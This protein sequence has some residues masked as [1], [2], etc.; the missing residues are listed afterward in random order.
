MSVRPHTEQVAVIFSA[1]IFD[2]KWRCF[3]FGFCKRLCS[4]HGKSVTLIKGVSETDKYGR[5]LRYIIVDNIYVN[6]ELVLQ[7]FATAV[8][9]PPDISCATTFQTAQRQ[10]SSA[11]VGPWAMPTQVPLPTQVPVSD[12]GGGGGGNCSPSYPGVCIPHPPPD[13]TAVTFRLDDLRS[14]NLIHI[15]S[16]EIRM[17]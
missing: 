10:A 12:N 7:G 17:E 6:Y 13:L 15:I 8:T 3:W 2:N 9:Y 1:S 4:Q 5:L 11:V 16:I 14:C